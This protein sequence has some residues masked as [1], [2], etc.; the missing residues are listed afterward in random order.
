MAKLANSTKTNEDNWLFSFF[1]LVAFSQQS[2][3][4]RRNSHHR[5]SN[6]NYVKIFQQETNEPKKS[7]KLLA[8]WD[9]ENSAGSIPKMWELELIGNRLR[10]DSL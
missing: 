5:I 6:Q 10:I 1:P 9:N 3:D 8:V 7:G 4:G 2:L